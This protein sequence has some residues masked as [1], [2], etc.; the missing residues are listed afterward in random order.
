MPVVIS[1]HRLRALRHTP[2]AESVPPLSTP[3][4]RVALCTATRGLGQG[5]ADAMP[6]A[7]CDSQQR[8]ADGATPVHSGVREE[9][10][11]DLPRP[12]AC[13]RTAGAT[14]PDA[15][16]PPH[17]QH[18]S[19]SAAA[20]G[21]AN[22]A[23]TT[24]RLESDSDGALAVL[25]SIFRSKLEAVVACSA[26]CQ[27]QAISEAETEIGVEAQVSRSGS[28]VHGEVRSM[29]SRCQACGCKGSPTFYHDGS[30]VVGVLCEICG[31]LG[32]LSC[33]TCPEVFPED[34]EPD[35]QSQPGSCQACGCKGSP[36]YYHGSS[37]VM[38]EIC[39]HLGHLSRASLAA[40]KDEKDARSESSDRGEAEHKWILQQGAASAHQRLDA[41]ESKQESGDCDRLPQVHVHPQTRVR[42]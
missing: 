17:L 19:A 36:T 29:L 10:V 33:S 5:A 42:V 39:G 34:A 11:S 13:A 27:D 12:H 2:M 25:E 37:K 31:H 35:T 6:R 24:D 1:Q 21:H 16:T 7:G 26:R 38:C 8:L 4:L 23:D 40:T 30:Q 3:S 20:A 14:A 28:S 9:A 22:G 32:P 41:A 15:S 18:V